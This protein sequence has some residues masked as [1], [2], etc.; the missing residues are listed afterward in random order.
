[1]KSPITLETWEF[2]LYKVQDFVASCLNYTKKYTTRVN[3]AI[4]ILII[5]YI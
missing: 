4:Y 1:M 3:Y 5:I 2:L